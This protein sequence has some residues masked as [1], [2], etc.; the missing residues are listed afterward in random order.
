MMSIFCNYDVMEQTPGSDELPET[1]DTGAMAVLKRMAKTV[2]HA[3][4]RHVLVR[5]GTIVSIDDLPVNIAGSLKRSRNNTGSANLDILEMELKAAL[6]AGYDILCDELTS[7]E[8]FI[9]DQLLVDLGFARFYYDDAGR[10]VITKDSRTYKSPEPVRWG[11][12]R[13]VEP[14]KK[15]KAA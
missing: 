14:I 6:K 2:R 11:F 1:K 10:K 13:P 7:H 8:T 15:L 9:V 5:P 12:D 4:L 3:I